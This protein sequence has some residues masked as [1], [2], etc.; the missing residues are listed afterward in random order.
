MATCRPGSY[1]R[2]RDSFEQAAGNTPTP[3]YLI[4]TIRNMAENPLKVALAYGK[5]T[6]HCCFCGIDLTDNRSVTMGYGPI[7]AGK[8]NLPWG[9]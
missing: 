3:D 9:E 8:Y 1:E 4:P 5:Q 2:R 7:C 6:G